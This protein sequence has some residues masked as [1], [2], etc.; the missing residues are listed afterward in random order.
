MKLEDTF[1][2]LVGGYYGVMELDEYSTKEFLL[3][4]IEMYIKDFVLQNP[5]ES[6]DYESF[7]REIEETMP[8]KTK[9]QDSLLVL[10]KVNA[11]M[12]AILLIKSRLSKLREEELEGY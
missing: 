4:D 2:Y 11:P 3:Y 8:L 7:A 6:F 5:I 12:E 10:P 1:K 9:L